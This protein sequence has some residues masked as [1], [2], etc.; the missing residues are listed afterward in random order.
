MHLVVA[1]APWAA[2]PMGGGRRQG[3]CKQPGAAAIA[4]T[5]AGTAAGARAGAW[6]RCRPSRMLIR[7]VPHYGREAAVPVKSID[8]AER[9]LPMEL[10]NRCSIRT[11]SMRCCSAAIS[12]ALRCGGSG[13]ASN[14]VGR[15]ATSSDSDCTFEGEQ[16]V[17]TWMSLKVMCNLRHSSV[18]DDP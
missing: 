3:R 15:R 7:A 9:P 14:E 6:G 13:S 4:T 11:A 12:V 2:G 18:H 17:E 1:A 16:C 5:G 10:V 8:D